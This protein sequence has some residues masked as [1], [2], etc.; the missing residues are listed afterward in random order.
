M[1]LLRDKL[2]EQGTMQP[3]YTPERVPV[4]PKERKSR[5][6]IPGEY[7]RVG[8]QIEAPSVLAGVAAGRVIQTPTS[9][10]TL[11]GGGGGNNRPWSFRKYKR[12]D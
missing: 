3:R 6:P 9:T 10:I 5:R 2:V 8:T 1:G 7:T 12:E 11:Y 4:H